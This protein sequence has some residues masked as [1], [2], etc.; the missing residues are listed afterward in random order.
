LFLDMR[1]WLDVRLD[2]LFWELELIMLLV[3]FKALEIRLFI[4]DFRLSVKSFDIES[5]EFCSMANTITNELKIN[6]IDNVI[7]IP[8]KIAFMLIISNGIVLY[9]FLATISISSDKSK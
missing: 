8:Y 6:N 2:S 4:L 9:Y 1:T 3:L 7:M 5:V